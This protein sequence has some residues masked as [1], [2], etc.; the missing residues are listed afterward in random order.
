MNT[1]ELSKKEMIQYGLNL[2]NVLGF[3]FALYLL[4][5]GFQNEVFTS[6]QALRNLLETMGPGAP[7]GFIFIQI[8]QTV[9]PIIPG[10][11]TIPMGSIIFGMGYGFFLNFTGIIIGSVI[12]FWLARRFGR[13][14]VELLVNKNQFNKY[15]RWL[16]DSQRFDKLFTFGMFFPFSP[17][18]LLCYL[19]GLSRISFKKYFL[20]LSLGKPLTLFIYSYGMIEVLQFAFQLFA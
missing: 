1:F 20:I 4:Y 2:L 7:I 12:N 11:L 19:A 18:D 17:A 6:E 8:I 14:L 10:A 15:I 9:I 5:W 3:L 16:D 13:P